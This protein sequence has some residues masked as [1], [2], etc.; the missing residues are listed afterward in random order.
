MKTKLFEMTK[1]KK[2]NLLNIVIEK[3]RKINLDQ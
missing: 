2:E 3:K 1:G